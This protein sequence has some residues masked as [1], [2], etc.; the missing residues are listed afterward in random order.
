MDSQKIL[1]EIPDRSFGLFQII[2]CGNKFFIKITDLTTNSFEY[3]QLDKENTKRII[4]FLQNTQVY[5][6]ND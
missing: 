6:S 5:E 3:F 4:E 1:F 2:L